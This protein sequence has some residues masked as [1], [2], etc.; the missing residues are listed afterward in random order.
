VSAEHGRVVTTDT[1]T[2]PDRAAELRCAATA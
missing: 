2:S 1:F